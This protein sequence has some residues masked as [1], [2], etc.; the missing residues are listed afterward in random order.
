[1]PAFTFDEQEIWKNCTKGSNAVNAK[2]YLNFTWVFVDLIRFKHLASLLVP[3]A[4]ASAFRDLIP[5][6]QVKWSESHVNEFIAIYN[7]L[8]AAKHSDSGMPFYFMPL[9]SFGSLHSFCL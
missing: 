2:L 9:F 8:C 1:M 4:G 7:D 6:L 3:S 5:F